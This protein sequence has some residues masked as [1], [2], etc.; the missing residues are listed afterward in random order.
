MEKRKVVGILFFI[1][2]LL[3]VINISLKKPPRPIK[4][5]NGKELTSEEIKAKFFDAMKNV[6]LDSNWIKMK[7]NYG[8]DRKWLPEYYFV[9]IPT[10]LPI[11]VVVRELQSEFDNSNVELDC[12]E[13]KTNGSTSINFVSHEELRQKAVL[14]YDSDIRRNAGTIGLMVLVPNNIGETE[15]GSLLD[16]PEYFTSIL[17]PSKTA[18]KLKKEIKKRDKNYA[19]LLNDDITPMDYSLKSSYPNSRIK[20]AISAIVANFSDADFFMIDNNSSIFFSSKYPVI[21]NEFRKRRIKLAEENSFVDL[22]SEGEKKMEMDFEKVVRKTKGGKSVEIILTV[23]G[24]HDLLNDIS[25]FRKIGYKFVNPG[26]L[27]FQ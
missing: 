27:I 23:K 5:N 9:E 25:K 14:V 16:I 2:I 26:S 21:G 13:E 11:P 4:K 15:F 8:R 10:D 7:R 18:T 17:V 22:T 1:A 24:L 19:I 12:L 6:G 3:L 20:N